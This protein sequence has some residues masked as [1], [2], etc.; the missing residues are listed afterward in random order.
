[1]IDTGSEQPVKVSVDP[2]TGPYIRLTIKA[3]DRVSQLLRDN[4]VKFWIN[5]H[6]VS[7]D[8]K[9]GIAWIWIHEQTDPHQVQSL[10]DSA[11]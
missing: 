11:A 2:D 1:M 9:P 10:L 7:F 6:V 8:G 3:L 4:G 5:P